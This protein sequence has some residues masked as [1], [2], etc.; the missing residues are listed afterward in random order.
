MVEDRDA[1]QQSRWAVQASAA[2]AEE[3]LPLFP[4]FVDKP[5][6]L[7][8]DF[9]NRWRGA[10]C[11]TELGLTAEQSA[12]LDQVQRLIDSLS[13]EGHSEQSVRCDHA[14]TALRD[15]AKEA[16]RVQG[17]PPELPQMGVVPMFPAADAPQQPTVFGRG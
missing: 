13:A 1:L 11:R 15:A 9:D 7:V 10:G 5:F 6:E 8:D 4:D 3:Q 16:L 17:W 12:A 2:D 14:W